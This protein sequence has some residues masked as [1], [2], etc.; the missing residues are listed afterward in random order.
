VHPAALPSDVLLAQCAQ[1]ARRR[2]GPGGQHRNKVETGVV[3]VHE[4]TGITA[5]ASERRSRRQNADVALGRLRRQLALDVRTPAGAC[6]PAVPP[7]ALWRSR[8]RGGRITINPRHADF[9]ALVAEAFDVLHALEFDLGAA[10]A[11]LGASSTQLVRLLGKEPRA[12]LAVNEAR[13]E[14]GLHPLRG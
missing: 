13:A 10:A 8:C 9:P 14:R 11:A 6:P 2:S 3:L 12:L 5:Q 4:P 7:S 1:T